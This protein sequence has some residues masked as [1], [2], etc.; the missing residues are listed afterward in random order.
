MQVRIFLPHPDAFK[1]F[2]YTQTRPLIQAGL[3]QPFFISHY[4]FTDEDKSDTNIELLPPH[5]RFNTG[6]VDQQGHP[7]TVHASIRFRYRETGGFQITKK[8]AAMIP[9]DC[10]YSDLREFTMPD[11]LSHGRFSDYVNQADHE[12]R[13]QMIG[14]VLHHNSRLLLD[15]L[16]DGPNGVTQETSNDALNTT[17]KTPIQSVV[18]MILN[19]HFLGNK[20][21]I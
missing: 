18:H 19:A 15:T 14:E 13:A 9:Q 11:G 3:D 5:F 2:H 6:K 4:L 17:L 1:T 16:R 8:V 12:C 7:I 20:V 10:W 21:G